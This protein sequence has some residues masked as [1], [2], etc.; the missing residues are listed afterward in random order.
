MRPLLTTTDV[1]ILEALCKYSPRNLSKVAKAVGISRHAL[2]FRLRRMKSN[3][4]IF[5]RIHTSVYHTNIGLKKAVVFLEAEPGMEHL[6]FECLKSNEFWLYI[7][8]TF[9][10]GEGCIAIY[11]IPAD[12]YNEFEEFIYKLKRLRVA[13]KIQIYWSTC[14]QGGR[15]S[16]TWFDS[17][18]DNWVFNWEDWIKEVQTQDTDL[19]YTLIEPKSYQICADEIDVQLLMWMELDATKSINEIAEKL[20]ISRQRALYHYKNHLLKRNL[21]EGY[22]VFIMRYGNNPFVMAYFLLSF[23]DYERFAKFTKSCLDKFFVLTM[24]KVLG[25]NMLIMEIFLPFSEFR[26]FIDTLSTMA[27][28]KLI[29]S[30]KYAIQDLRMRCRQTFSGEF[31]KNNT[32]I[33]D[34]KKHIETLQQK[35]LNLCKND[36]RKHRRTEN[37]QAI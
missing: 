6:L 12:H 11:A 2:E 19:P 10:M 14:F 25:Q 7:C 16:S 31:F 36:N 22:E 28:M 4:E 24:G 5:L 1:K 9:G 35:I 15:I 18:T 8:R 34:H 32:W 13:S 37:T 33:Y 21:I 29:K 3:P 20:G 30:Y 26:N 23:H 17:Q 27:Q